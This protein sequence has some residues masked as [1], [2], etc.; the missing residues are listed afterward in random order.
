[1]P[2]ESDLADEIAQHLEDRYLDLTAAGA[3]PDAA[4]RQI[5]AELNN[6]HP[7]QASARR[8]PPRDPVAPGDART[9]SFLGSLWRDLRYSIRSMW[10]SP[11]FAAFVILTL[12]LGIGANTTVFT[13]LN[14][15]ILNPL[16]VRDPGRLVALEDVDAN[17]SKGR[18]PFPIS[19]PDLQDY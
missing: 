3:T 15:L 12:A 14:T 5:A 18:T 11:I 9:T 13:V 19:Y 7:L 1:G 10:R 2:A 8:L 6:V 17:P 16:P 4:Y